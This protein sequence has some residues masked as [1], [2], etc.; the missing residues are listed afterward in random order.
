MLEEERLTQIQAQ[1]G[2]L[3]SKRSIPEPVHEVLSET[4]SLFPVSVSM[5]IPLYDGKTDPVAHVQTYRTWMAIAKATATTLCNAFPLTLSRP[6][7]A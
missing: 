3:L 2:R 6:S 5:T 4:Q 1:I 7:Q